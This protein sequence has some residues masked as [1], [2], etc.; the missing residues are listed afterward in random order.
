MALT[1]EQLRKG[2]RYW[3]EKQ[4]L[5][6]QD[7]H[8]AFYRDS[9]SLPLNGFFNQE[10]WDRFYP[11]LRVWQATRGK[12]CGR[13]ILTSRAQNRFEELST[14]WATAVAPRLGGDISGVEWNQ[15]AAFPLVVAEIKPLKY[16]SPVFTTKFCHFLAPRIFPVVD[17]KAMGNP[18]PNYEAYFKYAQAEWRGT[19]VTT[20]DELITILT[21]EIGA[22]LFQEFPLKCKVI[23]ICMIG[24]RHG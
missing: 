20:Q 14:K 4:P 12:G 18:F 2:I 23:E 19:D 21:D 6:D 5:W 1:V 17:N 3:H 15:I 16:P 9:A 7:F 24:R 8:N 10:W 22:I 13:K 11:I